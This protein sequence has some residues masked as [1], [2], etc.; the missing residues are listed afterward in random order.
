MSVAFRR[1]A[2]LLAPA[3]A[4]AVA[5]PSAAQTLASDAKCLI[6]S[7]VFAQSSDPKAKQAGIEARYFYLGRLTGSTAQI[8]T[9]LAAQGKTITKQNAGPTMQACA[10][11]VVQKANEVQAIGQRLSS[12]P[13]GR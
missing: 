8:E 2:L 9:A 1:S 13:A 12:R 3:L 5:V 4:A 7:N 10:R 11:T 6:V